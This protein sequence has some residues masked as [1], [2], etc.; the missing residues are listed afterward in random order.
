MKEAEKKKILLVDDVRLFLNLEETFF[1]RTGC[2]IFTAQNGTE[3]LQI[4]REQKPNLILLD[5]LMPGMNGEE[6]CRRIKSDPNLKSTVIIMVSTQSDEE[7]IARCKQAGC[8]DYVTKPIHQP[9][10]LRKAADHLKIP[11]R[12][13]FRILV[14]LEVEGKYHQGFF[15][16]TSSDISLSGMLVETDRRIE[17]GEKVNLQFVIPGD[18]EPMTIGGVVARVDEISFRDRLGIGIHFENLNHEQQQV[19]TTFIESRLF[20]K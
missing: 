15:I 13:H 10:L 8:D 2:Q 4:A 5:L 12:V 7:T 11:Y 16:G 14:R 17:R 9:D 3:A 1:R 18:P 19:I 6:V 20:D